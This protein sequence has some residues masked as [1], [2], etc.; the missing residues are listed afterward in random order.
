[1]SGACLEAASN[2]IGRLAQIVVEVRRFLKSGPTSFD[3]KEKP[4][5][6]DYAQTFINSESTDVLVTS[7]QFLKPK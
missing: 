7:S 3:L 6:N 4:N 2:Q 1:M 5:Y